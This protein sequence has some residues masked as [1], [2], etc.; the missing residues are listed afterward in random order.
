MH[1]GINMKES[2]KKALKY[3]KDGKVFK[4]LSGKGFELY[5]VE[6]NTG[7]YEVRYD[8]NKDMW[9]CNCKNIKLCACAHIQAVIIYKGNE[10]IK[11]TSITPPP[12]QSLYH[13][14]G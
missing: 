1:I 5:G 9:T 14:E 8:L 12:H 7:I 6:A 4:L 11:C 3:V 13:R 10:K 2:T